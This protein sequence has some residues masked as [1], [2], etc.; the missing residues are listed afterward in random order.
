MG[1]FKFGGKPMFCM[2]SIAPP[3]YLSPENDGGTNNQS[4]IYKFRLEIPSGKVV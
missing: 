2:Y 4:S 1:H 3:N